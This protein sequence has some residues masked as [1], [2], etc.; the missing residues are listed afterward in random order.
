MMTDIGAIATLLSK[1]FGFVVDPDGL[2][3][4]R[5]EYKIE[6]LNAAFKIAMDKG[7]VV[8]LD[9]LFT[10]LRELSDASG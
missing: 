1:I 2:A 9:L 7:D 4:M 10:T 8:A 3:A 5:R 6:V